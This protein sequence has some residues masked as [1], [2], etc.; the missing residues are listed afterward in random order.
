MAPYYSRAERYMG[1]YSNKD[2]LWNLPGGEFSGAIGMRC[3]EWLLRR[4]VERLKPK[5]AKMELV[6][7]A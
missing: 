6:E 4:G 3:G 5:G 2:R 1:V 7:R